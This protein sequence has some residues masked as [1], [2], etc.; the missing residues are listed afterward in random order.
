MGEG[1]DLKTGNVDCS[2]KFEI[3]TEILLKIQVLQDVTPCRLA[4][5]NSILTV[6]F[7][8]SRLVAA[9]TV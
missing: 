9:L 4:K 6:Q 8:L 7:G 5:T 3:S 2:T 1:S